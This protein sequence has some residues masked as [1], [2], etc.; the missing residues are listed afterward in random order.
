M[1]F[2][3]AKCGPGFSLDVPGLVLCKQPG[4][5]LMAPLGQREEDRS[6]FADPL[7]GI[8]NGTKSRLKSNQPLL[9]S[10]SSSMLKG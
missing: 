6:G 10:L 8:W 7:W 1:S 3:Q 9:I 4:I 5:L 2:S